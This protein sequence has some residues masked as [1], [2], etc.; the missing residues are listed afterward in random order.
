MGDETMTKEEIISI[1]I[2]KY[3]D[4]MRIKK[5]EKAENS[6]LDYQITVTKAKLQSFGVNTEDLEKI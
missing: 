3:A 2:D 6:E 4:L 5:A 1:L